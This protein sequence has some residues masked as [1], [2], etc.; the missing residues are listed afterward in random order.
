[1]W[2]VFLSPVLLRTQLV[3]HFLTPLLLGHA[4]SLQAPRGA[5]V[6]SYAVHQKPPGLAGPSPAPPSAAGAAVQSEGSYPACTLHQRM[7]SQRGD[8]FIHIHSLF[9]SFIA[10]FFHCVINSFCRSFIFHSFIGLSFHSFIVTFNHCFKLSFN[11]SFSHSVMQSVFHIS[12]LS[13]SLQLTTETTVVMIPYIV[14]TNQSNQ[15]YISLSFFHF[16]I[17]S[18]F[19]SLAFFISFYF[20]VFH[21]SWVSSST[22]TSIF[23]LDRCAS[24][25]PWPLVMTQKAQ[26]NACIILQLT[27]GESWTY[28]YTPRTTEICDPRLTINL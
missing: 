12:F 9:C 23:C 5:Q 16:F 4:H 19:L 6:C 26:P 17:L 3:V 14:S 18:F 8:S 10:L 11:R 27:R 15:T 7:V 21:S 22:A 25:H 13:Y 1:M 28:K 20:S 24:F 2:W